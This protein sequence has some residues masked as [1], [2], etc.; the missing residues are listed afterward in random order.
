MGFDPA[1]GT[2]L[3]SP[4][5]LESCP[6]CGAPARVEKVIRPTTALGVDSATLV[7]VPIGEHTVYFTLDCPLHSTPLHPQPDMSLA[8]YESAYQAGLERATLTLVHQQTLPDGVPGQLLIGHGVGSLILE[9]G[10]IRAILKAV[11]AD[12]AEQREVYG[13]FPDV[14]VVVERALTDTERQ[15]IRVL[16]RELIETVF[17]GR[18]WSLGISR[19]VSLDT[20]ALGRVDFASS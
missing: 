15:R 20:P 1:N 19:S 13:L 14:L 18:T 6:V 10:R 5:D 3:D 11:D 9:P 17:P 4:L 7:G 8:E 16:A 12:T 2:L